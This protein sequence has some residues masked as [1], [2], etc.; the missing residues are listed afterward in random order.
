MAEG[1]L[2]YSL[3][4]SHDTEYR[5]LPAARSGRRPTR[6][7]RRISRLAARAGCAP[8]R[9]SIHWFQPWRCRSTPTATSRCRPSRGGGPQAAEKRKNGQARQGEPEP[10]RSRAEAGRSAQQSKGAAKKNAGQAIGPSVAS[11]L[12]E[13]RRRSEN[14]GAN[15]CSFD[16]LFGVDPSVANED[17]IWDDSPGFILDEQSPYQ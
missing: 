12:Q 4:L 8:T 5:G 6:P 3:A 16:R 15:D 10:G 11:P 17:V 9:C 14:R 13:G 7:A 2:R 1:G